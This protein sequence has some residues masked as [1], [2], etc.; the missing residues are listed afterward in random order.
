MSEITRQVRFRVAG[1]TLA[2]MAFCFMSYHQALAYFRIGDGARS[3]QAAATST[4]ALDN[5]LVDQPEARKNHNEILAFRFTIV[6]QL[7]DDEISERVVARVMSADGPDGIIELNLAGDYPGKSASYR[8]GDGIH[9]PPAHRRV[10]IEL[11]VDYVPEN[12][13]GTAGEPVHWANTL[14]M[15]VANGAYLQV[16][17][18]KDGSF[19]LQP[20][21]SK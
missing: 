7:S 17:I 8:D 18:E 10:D 2:L 1:G 4:A 13:D 16:T 21:P 9:G 6:D 14:S 5:V 20:V 19:S 11:S 3:T 12:S 15:T